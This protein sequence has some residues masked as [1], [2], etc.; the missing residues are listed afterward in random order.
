M[1]IEDVVVPDVSG[2]NMNNVKEILLAYGL[3][4][5][6]VGAGHRDSYA[7][8]AVNQSVEPGEEVPPATVIGVE[9]RQAAQD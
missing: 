6:S 5:E 4:F 8:Y 1:E 9:F 7:A 2:D 3:N